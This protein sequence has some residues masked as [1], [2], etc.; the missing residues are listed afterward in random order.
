M[1]TNNSETNQGEQKESEC[2][3]CKFVL[4][5]AFSTL[6]LVLVFTFFF[7]LQPPPVIEPLPPSLQSS[8]TNGEEVK[9]NEN[10]N[11]APSSEEVSPLVMPK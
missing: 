8:A 4:Y 9:I 6:F 5:F 3:M 7:R 10:P 2:T 11:Q 1:T